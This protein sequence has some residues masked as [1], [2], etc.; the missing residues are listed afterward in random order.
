MSFTQ[1]QVTVNS[2]ANH[3][4]I[5]FLNAFACAE[6]REL[7]EDNYEAPPRGTNIN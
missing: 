2:D 6:M 5:G 3:L 1:L 7:N 4:K